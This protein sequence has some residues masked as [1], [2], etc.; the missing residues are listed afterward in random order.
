MIN[1]CRGSEERFDEMTKVVSSTF[2]K[3]TKN[4]SVF[5]ILII[6]SHDTAHFKLGVDCDGKEGR[7]H[8]CSLLSLVQGLYPITYTKLFFLSGCLVCVVSFQIR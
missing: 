2:G 8:N 3:K 7:F 5:E 6:I 1:I 4:D